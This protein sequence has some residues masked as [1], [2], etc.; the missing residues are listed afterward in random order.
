MERTEVRRLATLK[1]EEVL[2]LAEGWLKHISSVIRGDTICMSGLKRKMLREWL[3]ERG[4]GLESAVDLH[5]FY[6]V[7]EEVAP[8]LGWRVVRDMRNSRHKARVI[9]RRVG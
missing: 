2:G 6:H 5:L 8:K 7:L 1:Y 9:L 3:R 4:Y